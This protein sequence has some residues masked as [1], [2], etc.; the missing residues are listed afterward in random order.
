MSDAPIT[1][2][3]LPGRILTLDEVAERVHLSTRTVY[4][5]ILAGDLEASQL[6]QRR[7]GWRV[8]ESALDAWMVKRSNRTRPPRPLADVRPVEPDSR[9]VRPAIGGMPVGGRLSVG[10]HMGRRVA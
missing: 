7:G 4:R 6:T 8:Y 1:A 3:E 9:S 2:D 10:P 5:A